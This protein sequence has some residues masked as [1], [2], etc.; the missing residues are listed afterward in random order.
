MLAPKVREVVL[1]RGHWARRA[2]RKTCTRGFA[3]L[4]LSLPGKDEQFRKSW[5]H[6]HTV[7]QMRQ[8]QIRLLLQ[9]PLP[10]KKR[11]HYG[12][13]GKLRKLCQRLMMAI[14]RVYSTRSGLSYV[15]LLRIGPISACE[16]ALR[17]ARYQLCQG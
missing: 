13:G 6:P 14:P 9:R 10:E 16:N 8:E 4:P 15:T 5:P 2:G 12:S 3:A 7:R 17:C 1:H 11:R